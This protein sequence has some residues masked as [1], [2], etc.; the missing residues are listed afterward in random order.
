MVILLL[1]SLI[2]AGLTMGVSSALSSQ[3]VSKQ[4]VASDLQ[5][6]SAIETAAAGVA[7]GK[8][9]SPSPPATPSPSPTATPNR[10]PSR[11]PALSP[12]PS[13]SASPSPTPTPSQ[14]PLPLPTEVAAP[15]APAGAPQMLGFSCARIDYVDLAQ[16]HQQLATLSGA[17]TGSCAAF[18]LGLP[19][20]PGR[21]LIWLQTMRPLASATAQLATSTSCAPTSATQCSTAADSQAP[22]TRLR[23]DCPWAQTGAPVLVL[24]TTSS[25]SPSLK[26]VVR[27]APR[28]PTGN[29]V[30]MVAVPTGTSPGYEQADLAMTS[31][32]IRLL[33]E[34]ELR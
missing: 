31:S 2:A 34:G 15:Q 32:G 21:V 20:S 25:L 33:F 8:C 16:V 6:Q 19:V 7:S 18:S 4:I 5:V 9:G 22:F 27:W 23:L 24:A 17:G 3:R 11:A 12:S 10:S 29:S 26:T 30:A 28:N 13:P 1:L 14:Q